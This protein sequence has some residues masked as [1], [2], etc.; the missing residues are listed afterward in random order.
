MK[1]LLIGLGCGGPELVAVA[2]LLSSQRDAR[3]SYERFLLP[4]KP[5]A[6]GVRQYIREIVALPEA[7]AGDVGMT[8]LPAVE[9]VAAAMPGAKFFCVMPDRDVFVKQMLADFKEVRE[10]DT[11]GRVLH[12]TG[13]SWDLGLVV[14]KGSRPRE[15][16]V[17]WWGDYAEECMRL[18]KELPGRFRIWEADE[19][20]TDAG[21]LD[22]LRF[23]G[24]GSSRFVF[25]V[26]PVRN[27]PIHKGLIRLVGDVLAAH[28]KRKP[29]TKQPGGEEKEN[30]GSTSAED[31]DLASE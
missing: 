16:F 28:P 8:W 25:G 31:S 4:W 9:Q 21:A 19:L 26:G 7:F 6:H 20:K 13:M 12:G 10:G 1:H 15:T 11:E 18:E 30:D 5:D 23:A 2:H 22:V 14:R 29:K 24:F 27:M 3:V 17:N